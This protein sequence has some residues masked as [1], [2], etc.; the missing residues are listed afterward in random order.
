[1][2]KYSLLILLP[3]LILGMCSVGCGSSRKV[4]K[5]FTLANLGKDVNFHTD[6]QQG[7]LDEEDVEKV[8]EEAKGVTEYSIPNSVKLSWGCQEELSEYVVGIGEKKDL[9]DQKEY[10]VSGATELELYNLK[11]ATNKTIEAEDGKSNTIYWK[12]ETI[13]RKNKNI[14]NN[15][16]ANFKIEL[17]RHINSSNK[18]L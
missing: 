4:D 3:S 18:V 6:F 2:K 9:S 11:I 13:F 17:H 12:S 16:E 8:P 5:R 10:T 1:M 14:D 7:Y 15:Y